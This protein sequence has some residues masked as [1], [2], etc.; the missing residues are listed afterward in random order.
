MLD[1]RVDGGDSPE[2]HASFSASTLPSQVTQERPEAGT[3]GP[4]TTDSVEQCGLVGCLEKGA[5]GNSIRLR[6]H[7]TRSDCALL[8]GVRSARPQRTGAQD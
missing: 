3:L 8:P 2:A 6:K 5:G 1:G 4:E 7:N